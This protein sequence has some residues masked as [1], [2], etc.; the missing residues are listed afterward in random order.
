MK[1]FITLPSKQVFGKTDT[2]F[3][4]PE[5]HFLV[6]GTIIDSATSPCKTALSKA[7]VKKN[8]MGSRKQTYQREQKVVTDC[9]NSFI[10]FHFFISILEPLTNSWF[11]VPTTK[12]SIFM[13]F[14]SVWV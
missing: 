11:N 12:M 3:K 4:K 2:F 9:F 5:V 7:K 14:A 8:R 13:H 1:V 10:L 6:E